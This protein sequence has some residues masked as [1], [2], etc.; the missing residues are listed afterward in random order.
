MLAIAF[1]MTYFNMK[2]WTASDL[3]KTKVVKDM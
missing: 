3:P 2:K 1:E